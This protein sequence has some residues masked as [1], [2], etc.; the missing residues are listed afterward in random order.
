MLSGKVRC[1]RPGLDTAPQ[2]LARRGSCD[3]SLSHNRG[4]EAFYGARRVDR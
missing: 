1:R 2:S 4:Q 3:L